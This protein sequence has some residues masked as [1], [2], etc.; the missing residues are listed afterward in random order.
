MNDKSS[1]KHIRRN[2][3]A[4]ILVSAY[5]QGLNFVGTALLSR[6]LPPE[7]FGL[8]AMAGTLTG[9]FQLLATGGLLTAVIR[10]KVF[11]GGVFSAMMIVTTGV[12]CL[13]AGIALAAA[14]PLAD[15]YGEPRL[16]PIVAWLGA[17][18]VL[19]AFC[20][21]PRAVIEREFSYGVRTIVTTVA[22]TLALGAALLAAI[23][24]WGVWALV[25]R[26]LCHAAVVAL[27]Q[28]V[29][30][31]PRLSRPRWG[32]ELRDA[33]RLGA[34]LM[35]FGIVKFFGT[36][37]DQ[38]LIGRE[39]GSETLAFYT[40]AVTLSKLPGS[41]L[42]MALGGTLMAYLAVAR[43][44]L[45]ELQRRFLG[46]VRPLALVMPPCA[47]LVGVLAEP[48]VVFVYGESWREVSGLL[49]LLAI[50]VALAPLW[51]SWADL[52]SL[53]DRGRLVFVVVCGRTVLRASLL[54]I[55]IGHGIQVLVLGS[56][57]ANACVLFPGAS[58][59]AHRAL[60]L[61][62]RATLKEIGRV[63]GPLAVA[64]TVALSLRAWGAAWHPLLQLSSVALATVLSYGLVV[65]GLLGRN[66]MRVAT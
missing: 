34:W 23:D 39:L 31:W 60:G 19:Q 2:V 20:A 16:A 51:G 6:L 37:I 53:G 27:V 12:G 62:F 54:L 49:Q 36:D 17:G 4:A 64:A 13:L 38:I 59:I 55:L 5:V 65:Y 29:Y 33:Y 9:L 25:V 14:E 26:Q 30:A 24:G 50:E 1:G 56:V 45:Q 10:A 32:R 58:L 48:F 41:L 52:L 44:D 46:A 3:T 8:V 7:A 22:P 42:S 57:I 28:L 11:D 66:A 63:L 43:S 18:F 15:F 21:I 61:S 47:L 40:R 35:A